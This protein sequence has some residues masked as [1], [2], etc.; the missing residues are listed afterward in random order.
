MCYLRRLF[1]KCLRTFLLSAVSLE[2]HSLTLSYFAFKSF[3]TLPP[4]LQTQL[5]VLI[6]HLFYPRGESQGQ[7]PYEESLRAPALFSLEESE[8]RPHCSYNILV[9]GRGGTDTD[10]CPL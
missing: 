5:C 8:G 10:L 4:S 9:R 6:S 1:Y 3:G 7:K 2:H